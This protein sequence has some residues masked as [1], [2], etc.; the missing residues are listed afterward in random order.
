ML[1]VAVRWDLWMESNMMIIDQEL[2]DKICT[3][4]AETVDYIKW[5]NSGFRLSLHFFLKI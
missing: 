4:P 5:E 1:P 3:Q 2:I